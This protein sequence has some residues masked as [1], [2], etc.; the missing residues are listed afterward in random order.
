MTDQDSSF[1]S[2]SGGPTPAGAGAPIYYV[3]LYRQ[4]WQDKYM[5]N[6]GNLDASYG[7]CVDVSNTWALLLGVGESWGN[8]KDLDYSSS[9]EW[10]ENAAKNHPKAGDIVILDGPPADPRYGHT[11]VAVHGNTAYH[12]MLFGQ[13]WPTGAPCRVTK[14]GYE[15]VKGWW[16]PRNRDIR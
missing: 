12:M 4:H 2:G 15:G 1:Q 3:R 9:C 7:Q 14:L 11:G 13:D 6:N 10:I 5:V 16:R 8:A